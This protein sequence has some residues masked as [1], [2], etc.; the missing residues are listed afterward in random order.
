MYFVDSR[1]QCYMC[2]H[3]S[4]ILHVLLNMCV[5]FQIITRKSMIVV[6]VHDTGDGT[7]ILLDQINDHIN[8]IAVVVF[9]DMLTNRM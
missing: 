6:R 1:S 7:K 4:K 8:I 2:C 9:R 5:F 3:D